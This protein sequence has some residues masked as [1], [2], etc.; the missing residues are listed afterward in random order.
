MNVNSV[1]VPSPCKTP[2]LGLFFPHETIITDLPWIDVNAARSSD[3]TDKL[4]VD[5][6]VIWPQEKSLW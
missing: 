3:Q 1:R 6:A 2:D 4:V 5:L